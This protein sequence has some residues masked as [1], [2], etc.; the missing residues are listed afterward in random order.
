MQK[1]LYCY[2]ALCGWCYGFSAVI[3]EFAANHPDLPVEVVSGG[4]IT[5]ARIG[6]IG[7]VAGYIGEAYKTVEKST[8]VTF[9]DGFLQGIL[10][11]GS[12]VFTSVP[13]GVAMAIFREARPDRQLAYATA[14]KR[15]IYYDGILPTD[16]GAYADR[17]ATLGADRDD[18]LAKMD[19]PAYLQLAEAD[20]TR[21]SRFGVTGFPTL[22]V[23]DGT[24]KLYAL[25]R[26]YLPLDRL[27]ANFRQLPTAQ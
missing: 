21:C 8:G 2:D 22:V 12:A 5:G 19:D 1:L 27:E 25:A 14:L 24:G 9:G 13:A 7:E 18:F 20:F 23:D 10:A 4:M 26:G 17:A 15:A 6:P 11:E 16:A 3:N